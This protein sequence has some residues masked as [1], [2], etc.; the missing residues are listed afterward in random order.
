MARSVPCFGVCSARSHFTSPYAP[1][2][3]YF[4]RVTRA[5]KS[6]QQNRPFPAVQAMKSIRGCPTAACDP[7]RTI[8]KSAKPPEY[9]VNR[10]YSTPDKHQPDHTNLLALPNPE[11]QLK[12]SIPLA[13]GAH[14]L[15][16]TYRL[17]S[18]YS[19]VT[20]D[21]SGVQSR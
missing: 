9:P 6:F 5:A 16:A 7:H 1:S 3:L 10:S 17:F 14:S 15:H 8:E 20:V 12:I 2:F 4:G 19:H 13:T 18:L 11:F 21:I